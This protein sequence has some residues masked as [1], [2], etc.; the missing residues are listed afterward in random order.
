MGGPLV[1]DL[2]AV[3]EGMAITVKWRGKPVFIRH[4]SAAEIEEAGAVDLADL[5]D[6][7]ADDH[8]PSYDKQ[9]I[10]GPILS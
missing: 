4:R 1:V 7:E 2:S 6:P 10:A 8:E 9:H 3:E 5:P